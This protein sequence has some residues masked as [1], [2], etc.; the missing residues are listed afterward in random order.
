MQLQQQIAIATSVLFVIM[1]LI[2]G[3]ELAFGSQR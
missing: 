1:R 2:S 3:N